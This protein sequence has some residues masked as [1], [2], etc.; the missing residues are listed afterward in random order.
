[1]D[2]NVED[3][4]TGRLPCIGS[5]IEPVDGFIRLDH[6]CAAILNKRFDGVP[7]GLVK[8]E[9]IR[10]MATGDNE[11]MPIRH[12]KAVT[13]CKRQFVFGNDPS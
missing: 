7:F 13:D 4:L 12:W 10:N 8:I 2:V 11:G 9:I 5:D 6:I 1:M 3:C